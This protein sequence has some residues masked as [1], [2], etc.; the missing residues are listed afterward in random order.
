MRLPEDFDLRLRSDGYLFE[1]A[2][3]QRCSQA[4]EL[5][6]IV[7]RDFAANMVGYHKAILRVLN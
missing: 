2:G 1:C 4:L 3:A 7:L 5:F 6:W